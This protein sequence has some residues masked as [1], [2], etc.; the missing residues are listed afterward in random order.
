LYEINKM[1][2]LFTR[3]EIYLYKKNSKKLKFVFAFYI[4]QGNDIF[5]YVHIQQLQ[6]VIAYGDIVM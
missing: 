1:P 6:W 4:D 3:L 2:F 5:S